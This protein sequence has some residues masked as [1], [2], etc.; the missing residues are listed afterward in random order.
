MELHNFLSCDFVFFLCP[1][2]QPIGLGA[3]E[4][5]P[6]G[7]FIQGGADRMDQATDLNLNE[8]PS[9]TQPCLCVPSPLVWQAKS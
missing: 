1:L 2:L 5:G 3:A 9:H 6:A 7:A 8:A 4:A